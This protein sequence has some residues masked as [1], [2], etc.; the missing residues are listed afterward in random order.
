MSTLTK[1]SGTTLR[2]YGTGATTTIKVEYW[3]DEHGEFYVTSSQL[4]LP[5]LG[6]WTDGDADMISDRLGNG[7]RERGRVLFVYQDQLLKGRRAVSAA[8]IHLEGSR[9][10]IQLRRIVSIADYK[11]HQG[12]WAVES[13]TIALSCLHRLSLKTGDARG[14]F[15]WLFDN[16]AAAADAKKRFCKGCEATITS[17]LGRGRGRAQRSQVKLRRCLLDQ[18]YEGAGPFTPS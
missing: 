2:L 6:A 13:A 8:L 5:D 14:C 17:P 4:A 16:K 12:R 15:D 10:R 11:Q 9:P 1:V 18:R 7:G 3:P